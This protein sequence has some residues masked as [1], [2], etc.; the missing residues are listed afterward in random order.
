MTDRFV[1]EIDDAFKRGIEI[2]PIKGI[3]SPQQLKIEMIKRVE[4][5]DKL[6]TAQKAHVID[7]I[8]TYNLP[9]VAWEESKYYQP[10]RLAWKAYEEMPSEYERRYPESRR[11]KTLVLKERLIPLFK[12]L[13]TPQ[14]GRLVAERL[15]PELD[16]KPSTLLRDLIPLVKA[17]WIERVERG[18]YRVTE[19]GKE[20]IEELV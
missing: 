19:A 11:I 16:I 7:N 6:S 20:I 12:E 1:E 17:G 10:E 14:R 8:I 4:M 13:Q 5:S 15:A 2:L 18:V 3:T 9:Q